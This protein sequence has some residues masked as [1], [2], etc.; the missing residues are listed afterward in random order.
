[1]Y[2]E[3]RLGFKYFLHN[4]DRLNKKLYLKKMLAATLLGNR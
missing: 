4:K 2:L 3:F 1:M